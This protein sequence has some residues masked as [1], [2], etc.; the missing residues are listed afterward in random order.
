MLFL[1]L[2]TLPFAAARQDD[3]AAARA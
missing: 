1:V 3:A 2:I